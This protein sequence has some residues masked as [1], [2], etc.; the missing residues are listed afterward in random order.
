MMVQPMREDRTQI[1]FTEWPTAEDVD[2][3]MGIH[4]GTGVGRTA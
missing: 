4:E 1:G 2:A 3:D